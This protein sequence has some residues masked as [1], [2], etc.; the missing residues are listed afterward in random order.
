MSPRYPLVQAVAAKLHT[1]H[2]VILLAPIAIGSWMAA[3]TFAMSDTNT[4][5][6][7]A[8]IQTA[9]NAVRP[10]LSG[11]KA[12]DTD[13]TSNSSAGASTIRPVVI[14]SPSVVIPGGGPSG[15]MSSG[16][17]GGGNLGGGMSHF[18]A[19]SAISPRPALPLP[20]DKLSS[21]G[22]LNLSPPAHT[23]P[24]PVPHPVAPPVARIPPITP[25]IIIA[26]TRPPVARPPVI[27]VPPF[28][29]QPFPVGRPIVGRPFVGGGG[30]ARH[31]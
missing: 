10:L 18:G 13:S 21:T 23:S 19:G 17:A 31:H 8:P 2:P 9:A 11:G 3:P 24:P 15:G 20:Q 5:N 27:V 4:A 16:G 30:F 26:P 12:S 14:P 7:P 25:P 29:V 22:T 6:L 1:V 28:R